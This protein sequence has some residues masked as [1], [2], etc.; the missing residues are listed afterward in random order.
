MVILGSDF[1]DT[2]SLGELYAAYPYAIDSVLY[3]ILFLGIARVT[4]GRRFAGRGGRAI[5]GAVGTI[6]AVTASLS[7]WRSGLT[8]GQ[9]GPLAWII[10]ALVLLLMLFDLLGH[11]GLAKS[12]PM[13][14]QRD[15][16]NHSTSSHHTTH[17][18]RVHHHRR[19]EEPASQRDPFHA[20]EVLEDESEMERLLSAFIKYIDAHGLD[21]HAGEFLIQVARTHRRTDRLYKQMLTALARS[22]WRADPDKKLLAADIES[23]IQAMFRNNALF[24]EAIRIAEAAIHGNNETL[25]REAITHLRLLE[26]ETIKLAEQLVVLVDR[27]S[28]KPHTTQNV[29]TPRGDGAF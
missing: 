16:S 26:R 23:M 14:D 17:H 3:L 25:L 11:A 10:L 7:A 8:L 12:R 13:P 18:W 21:R 24:I 28:R 15:R 5:V 9:L 19:H 2:L 22:G 29:N 1:L 27:L 20:N 4:L 6:L